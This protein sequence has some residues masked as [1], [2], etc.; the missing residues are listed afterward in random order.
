MAARHRAI[1]AVITSNTHGTR[2]EVPVGPEDS[3]D[4]DSVIDGFD[5]ATLDTGLFVRRLGR[6]SHTKWPA[7]EE[8]LRVSL[9]LP[10]FER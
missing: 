4:H 6:L 10:R 7:M 2:V 1:V 8:A 5:L 9:A 3:L